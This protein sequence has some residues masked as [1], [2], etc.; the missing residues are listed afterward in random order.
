[1]DLSLLFLFYKLKRIPRSL[2]VGHFIIVV[3]FWINA[4]MKT[5]NKTQLKFK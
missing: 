2:K 3:G 4:I 5:T 1:M